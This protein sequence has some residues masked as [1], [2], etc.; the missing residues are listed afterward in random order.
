[1]EAAM[2]TLP[3]P[4]PTQGLLLRAAACR[5]D[6]RVIPP[7]NLRGGTRVKV[8]TGLMQRAW[9]GPADDGHALTDAGYAVAGRKRPAPPEDLQPV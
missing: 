1:M 8:L 9:I 6:G 5:A 4:T 2:E 3:K 7:D